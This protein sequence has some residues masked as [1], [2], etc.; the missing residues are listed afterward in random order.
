MSDRRWI[1]RSIAPEVGRTV[2]VMMMLIAFESR[3]FIEN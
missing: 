2:L 3:V 1:E